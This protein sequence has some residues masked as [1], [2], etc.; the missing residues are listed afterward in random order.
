M[1]G[2]FPDNACLSVVTPP[3]HF[4][5]TP[6][7]ANGSSILDPSRRTDLIGRPV[8]P[9]GGL[10]DS[11]SCG[12]RELILSATD[13]ITNFDMDTFIDE[14]DILGLT[15]VEWLLNDYLVLLP[16]R[17][18]SQQ[19][20]TALVNTLAVQG[21][22]HRPLTEQCIR[23]ETATLGA[24]CAVTWEFHHA[25]EHSEPSRRRVCS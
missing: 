6:N 2:K 14:R 10:A 18:C 5:G 9:A 17:H 4:S 15:H 22:C 11:R 19:L 13:H 20:S 1:P 24:T 12:C 3:V 25:S 7:L 23:C 21:H 16:V 8:V